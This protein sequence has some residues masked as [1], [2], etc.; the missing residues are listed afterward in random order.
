MAGTDYLINCIEVAGTA[1]IRPDNDIPLRHGSFNAS[2]TRSGRKACA[3]I[4]AMALE[5]FGAEK[6]Y[7]PGYR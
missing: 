1:C 6:D 7:L 2:G 3:E 4:K 5:M